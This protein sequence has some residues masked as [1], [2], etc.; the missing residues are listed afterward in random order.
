MKK[1]F[2]KKS[3]EAHFLL[4]LVQNRLESLVHKA[5]SCSNFQNKNYYTYYNRWYKPLFFTTIFL[6]ITTIH[7]V[8]Q[9]LVKSHLE[10][11]GWLK[12]YAIKRY[13]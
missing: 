2:S 12:K 11:V 8:V 9:A 5:Y 3:L 1:I 7:L 6:K 4:Q 10:K 13:A